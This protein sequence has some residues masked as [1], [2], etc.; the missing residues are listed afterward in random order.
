MSERVWQLTTEQLAD[1]R[2]FKVVRKRGTSPRTNQE[3]TYYGLDQKDWVQIIARTRSGDLVM[4]AQFRPGAEVQSLEFPAGLIDQGETP[5]QA[6]LRELEEESGY[7]AAE[8]HMVGSIYPNPAIQSNRL[9][10]VFAD[11]CEPTGSVN[12]DEGED[13]SVRLVREPDLPEL[14]RSGVINHGLVLT[15]WQLYELWRQR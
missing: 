8:S 14:I 12:Q 13:V 9:Y 6:G 7:R 5:L 3:V 10:I 15:A 1:Y 4:V 2:I 11:G